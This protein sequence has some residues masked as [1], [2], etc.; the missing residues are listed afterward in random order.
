MSYGPMSAL[1]LQP[2]MCYSHPNGLRSLLKQPSIFCGE[3]EH[4]AMLIGGSLF[5][6]CICRIA[7]S[8]GQIALIIGI[9][10]DLRMFFARFASIHDHNCTKKNLRLLVLFVFGFL[11]V[12]AVAAWRIPKWSAR[13]GRENGHGSCVGPRKLEIWL[14]TCQRMLPRTPCPMV[15][16]STF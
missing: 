6:V 13:W 14:I 2:F 11:A 10:Y 4:R 7:M 15:D 9:M 8:S 1:A 3:E 12:C 16:V 5:F